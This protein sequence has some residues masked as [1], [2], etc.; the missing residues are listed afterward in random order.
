MVG[1]RISRAPRIPCRLSLIIKGKMMLYNGGIWGS[2]IRDETSHH[3]WWDKASSY[4]FSMKGWGGHNIANFFFSCKKH[5]TWIKS[6]GI[7]QTKPAERQSVKQLRHFKTVNIGKDWKSLE[8]AADKGM[9]GFLVA[10]KS[11]P[12][13][14]GDVGLTPESGR[15][16]GEGKGNPLQYSCLENPMNRGTWWAAVHRA[17][18]SRTWWRATYHAHMQR[19]EKG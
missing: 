7:H 11:L 16:P 2:F 18:K 3:Q 1:S 6:G 13:N 12:A 10:L 14:A 8:N 4:A 19:N 9:T 5:S 17:A 15:S